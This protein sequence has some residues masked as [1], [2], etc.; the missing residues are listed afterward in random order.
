VAY[1]RKDST[2]TSLAF[3]A[4]TIASFSAFSSAISSGC[5]AYSEN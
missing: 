4:G 2:V 1:K 3:P 5:P